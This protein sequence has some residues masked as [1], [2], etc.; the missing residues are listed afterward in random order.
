MRTI[1]SIL[2]GAAMVTALLVGGSEALALAVRPMPGAPG[3]E[4][5]PAAPLTGV[6]GA[7]NAF[8]AD[9]YGRLAATEGNLF[10][11]PNSIETALTMTYAGA[12]GN[13]ADEM[14]KVLHLSAIG[15]DAGNPAELHKTFGAFLRDLNAP[16]GPDG[17]PRGYQLS[18]ANALWGQKGHNFLQDFLGLVNTSYGA[19]LTDLDFANNAEAARVTINTWVEKQTQQKIQNLIAKGVLDGRTRLVLTNAIYFKGDWT[20]Q[21]KKDATKDARFNVT[22]DKTVTAPMMNRTGDYAYAEDAALQ[23]LKMPYVGNEVSMVVL[24]PKRVDG[25]ADLQKRL[26]AENLEMWGRGN[27]SQKVVLTMP[28]F[29]LTAQFELAKTLAAM[30]MTD[31]FSGGK[32]DFSGIDGQHYLYISNVIH[33]AYVDVNE[34]GTEAAAATAIGMR[35]MGAA[36]PPRQIVFKADHPFLFLIRHEKSGAILFMGRVSTPE[37]GAAAGK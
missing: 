19:A 12:R 9:L 2:I 6:A 36:L 15:A 18:V 10:F 23:V 17:K 3:A 22:A 7:N 14:A 32:A 28:K 1:T 37:G 11:S 21:F 29:K 26:T 8:A 31:A 25:L 33:K 16:N 4:P 5:A 30:G 13:T 20:S 24:L 34:E 27:R 35:T